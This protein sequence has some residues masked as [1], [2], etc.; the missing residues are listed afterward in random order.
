MN[1]Y[2]IAVNGIGGAKWDGVAIVCFSNRLR[3]CISWSSSTVCGVDGMA[4]GPTSPANL[5]VEAASIS[6]GLN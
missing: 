2:S 4:S 1:E 3:L 5:P 6:S